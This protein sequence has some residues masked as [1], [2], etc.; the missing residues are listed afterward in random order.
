MISFALIRVGLLT[1]AVGYGLPT[2][3]QTLHRLPRTQ[4]APSAPAPVAVTTPV[5]A[6]VPVAAPAAPQSAANQP[7]HRAQITFSTGLLSISA[8]NSSLNQILRE[9]GRLTGMKI[10]GGVTDER[11]YGNYGPADTA[12]ILSAL[13]RGTGSNMMLVLDDRES[14]RELMLTPRGGGPTPPNPNASR[15]RDEDLPPQREPRMPNAAGFANPQ[16]NTQPPPQNFQPARVPSAAA[17]VQAT[18]PAAP[19][20]DTTTPKSPSGVATPQQIYDQLM[21]LQQQQQ[22]NPAAPQ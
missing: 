17:P 14:P 15:D 18:P 21:R 13:L 2:L 3:A 19:V 11:V 20:T 9:I 12:T 10:T 4:P 7:A 1:A 16:Q 5:A 6:A 8:E 22:K